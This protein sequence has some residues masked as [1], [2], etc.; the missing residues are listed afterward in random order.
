MQSF[1]L[2]HWVR[3]GGLFDGGHSSVGNEVRH[4]NSL[5]GL[6]CFPSPVVILRSDGCEFQRGRLYLGLVTLVQQQKAGAGLSSRRVSP[7]PLA[8]PMSG[9]AD[10]F[11]Q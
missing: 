3:V 9:F 10:E 4:R 2:Q 6:C 7:A 8:L 5:L 11:L 1:V